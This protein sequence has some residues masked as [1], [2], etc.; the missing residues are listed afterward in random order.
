MRSVP[1][2]KQ[3]ALLK[4]MVAI[5]EEKTRLDDR[6]KSLMEKDLPAAVRDA[7]PANFPALYADF[8]AVYQKFSDFLLFRPLI[9]KR[10][11][12]LGGGFSSGKSTFLN[13]LLGGTRLLPTDIQP[14]TAVPAYL[15]HGDEEQATGINVF[16]SKIAMP[17]EDIGVLAHGFSTDEMDASD[18]EAPLGHILRSLFIRTPRQTFQHLA[19]LDTPGYSNAGS[20]GYAEQTDAD[21]AFRQLNASDAILWFVPADSGTLPQSDVE[22]LRKLSPDIPKT[23]IVNKADKAYSSE[24]LQ[25][26]VR[27][28]RDVLDLQGIRYEHI[29]TFSRKPACVCDRESILSYLTEMDA[30]QETSDFAYRFKQLFQACRDFYD[31]EIR[32]ERMK[33]SRLNKALTLAGDEAEVAQS[34]T[35]VTQDIKRDIEAQEAAKKRLHDVQQD[36]FTELKRVADEVGIAMPEPSEIDLLEGK[37]SDPA[38]IARK[39]AGDSTRSAAL[40]DVL[41][42]GLADVSSNLNRQ[43]GGSKH[44]D[45]LFKILQKELA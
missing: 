9:G 4:Q 35:E 18:E 45:V 21:I 5:K 39:L 34:L 11:V 20:A 15:I 22:F 37:M 42:H 33:L 8:Q 6:L 27:A 12:A 41:E 23:I 10:V 30:A 24:A 38:A 16:R 19:L 25:D 3:L 32:S 7:A 36:F 14:T 40:L 28:V 26:V 17:V 44:R 1:P 43:A 31:E 29:Y 13:T 2:E